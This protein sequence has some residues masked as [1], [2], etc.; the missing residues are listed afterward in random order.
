[1]SATV[2][3]QHLD[4]TTPL[5]AALVTVHIEPYGPEHRDWCDQRPYSYPNGAYVVVTRRHDKSLKYVFASTAGPTIDGLMAAA[6]ELA[7]LLDAQV[8]PP[9]PNPATQ[10]VSPS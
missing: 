7:Y 3:D 5:D 2:Q 1:M 10:V 8:A 4:D 9:G 6:H